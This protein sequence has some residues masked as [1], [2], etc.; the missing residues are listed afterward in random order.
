[1]QAKLLRALQEG[2]IQPVG[3]G[4]VEHIDVRVVAS[5]NRVLEAETAA[6]RFRED[7]YYRLAV[8]EM[9]VPPLRE[10]REDIPALA[11]EFRRRYAERFG[12]ADIRFSP[13]LI[14]ALSEAE[15]PGNVREL[16]NAIARMVA[17]SGGGEIGVEA[18]A[19]AP[20]RLVRNEPAAETPPERLLSLNEQIEAL[21][22]RVI[23]ETLAAVFWNQSTATRQLGLNR[24]TLRERLR[25]Y[26][27]PTTRPRR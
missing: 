15:W 7:L 13:E 17:L 10:R 22:R 3:A 6:G 18:F 24:G 14:Q 27:L 1:V 19:R 26:G 8:V 20:L 23:A 2:E 25:K 21:E 9:V 5:T 4:R 12:D 11:A 16:E